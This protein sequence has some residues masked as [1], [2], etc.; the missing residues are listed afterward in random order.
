MD[1]LLAPLA[2]PRYIIPRAVAAEPPRSS[3]GALSLA[4]RSAT[5]G[6]VSNHVVYHAIPAYLA[7]NKTRVQAFEKAWRT[8]VSPG[9]ALYYQDA[10]AA[11]IIEVQR[12]ENPFEATSQM[13]TLWH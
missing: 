11:A 3:L 4:L 5:V 1:E 2:S 12:G 7:A 13:R 10:K 8:H 6:A 9:E